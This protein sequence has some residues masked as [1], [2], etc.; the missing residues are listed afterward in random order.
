MVICTDTGC[1][2]KALEDTI[3]SCGAANVAVAETVGQL[4]LLLLLNGGKE[5]GSKAEKIGQVKLE[6]E[7]FL[8]GQNSRNFPFLFN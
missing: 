6:V 3:S 4:G 7:L 8:V 1:I 5:T 2:G